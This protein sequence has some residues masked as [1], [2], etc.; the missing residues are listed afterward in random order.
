MTCKKKVTQ[1]EYDNKMKKFENLKKKLS[2][3][4]KAKI[5]S[6]YSDPGNTW[7]DNF[8]YEQLDLQEDGLLTQLENLSKDIEESEIVV[9]GAVSPGKVDIYDKIRLLFIYDDGEQEDLV[10][11]LGNDDGD[12]SITL[13]SPLG[14]S[15]YNQKYGE[16]VEYFV[17]GKKI[18]VKIIEK[19]N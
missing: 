11:T 3:V 15:I 9:C 19:L 14:K 13:A 5:D 6:A 10:L 16:I 2:S 12:N 7:H 17:N 4:S 1:L 8:A 18:Q